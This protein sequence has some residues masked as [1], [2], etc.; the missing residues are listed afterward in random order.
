MQPF[1]ISLYS[2][3]QN[4]NNQRVREGLF[5]YLVYSVTMKI[6]AIWPFQRLLFPV[7]N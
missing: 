2:K 4:E 3:K 7:Q 6:L 1:G 5:F